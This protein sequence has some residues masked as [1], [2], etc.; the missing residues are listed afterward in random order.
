NHDSGDLSIL[1]GRGDGTFEPQRRIDATA[2]PFALVVGDFNNDGIPDIAVADSTPGPAQG[3]VLLG[4]GDGTFAPLPLRLPPGDPNR[5]DTVRSTDVNHDGNSDLLYSDFL[6]GTALLL[7]NGD[8]TF[9]APVQIQ[10]RNG[11]ALAVADLNADGN[12]DV[13]NSFYSLN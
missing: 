8:G 12:P 6:T 13:V 5:A 1:F 7:G 9:G 10:P 2:A 3:V 11:P 4:R